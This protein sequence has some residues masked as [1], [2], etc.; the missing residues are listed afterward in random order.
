VKKTLEV[1]EHRAEELGQ[2]EGLGPK[3]VK[4]IRE[5]WREQKG[6]R[7]LMIF[8]QDH[9]VSPVHAAKIF[10]HYG[11]EAVRVVSQNPIGL[12]ATSLGSVFSP[13]TGSR[14]RWGLKRAPRP[15]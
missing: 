11:W 1:I 7:E 15:G 10:R 9:D 4:M 12:Q 3:R 5:A 6:I 14:K 13:Q 2:V 8:L